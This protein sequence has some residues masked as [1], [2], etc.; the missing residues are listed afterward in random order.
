[1]FKNFLLL[2]W[3]NQYHHFLLK[4]FGVYKCV[5]DIDFKVIFGHLTYFTQWTIPDFYAIFRKKDK[6]SKAGNNSPIRLTQCRTQFKSPRKILCVLYLHYNVPFTFK[7]YGNSW[8]KTF[9][10]QRVLIGYNI[11]LAEL[12]YANCFPYF[13]SNVGDVVFHKRLKSISIPLSIWQNFCILKG[14]KSW[15]DGQILSSWLGDVIFF[16]LV[17]KWQ[18]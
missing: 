5:M 15:Y 6:V 13:W 16:V 17:E 14:C 7:W 3:V 10:S 4:V 9:Y 8:D 12:V 18:S 2:N 1:M 11:E